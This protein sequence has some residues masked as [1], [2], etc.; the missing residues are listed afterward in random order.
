MNPSNL[1]GDQIPLATLDVETNT[2]H[3]FNDENS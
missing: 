1:S 3:I 2:V